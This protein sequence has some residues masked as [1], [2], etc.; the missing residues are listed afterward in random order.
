[1]SQYRVVISETAEQNLRD[2]YLWYR[3]RNPEAANVWLTVMRRAVSSLS[4][5][6][7]AHPIA[8]E[9]DRFSTTIRQKTAGLSTPWRILFTV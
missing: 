8:P 5:F 1:M 2:A 6:P 9:S 4:S 7:D 3:D